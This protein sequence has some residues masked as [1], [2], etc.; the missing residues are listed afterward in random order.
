MNSN[1]DNFIGIF[2]NNDLNDYCS[3][4]VN[5]FDHIQGL[6]KTKSRQDIGTASKQNKDNEVYLF[7]DEQDPLILPEQ[8]G[9][10]RPFID[11]LDRCYKE[12]DNEC[13]G[14]L[15]ML[16]KHKLNPDIKIQKT[17]PGQGYHV[18]HCETNNA[19]YSRRLLLCMLYLNDV[20][21]GGETEFLYQSKR[22]S[23][24]A[25]RV[26]ICPAY[27]THTHRGNPPLKEAKYM[28][29]GWVEFVE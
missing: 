29:N 11:V 17:L 21:D 12:Y 5:F 8:F 20:K 7:M 26:V 15:Q 16:G 4:L 19:R 24:K 2:D 28:I 1:V 22:V 6:G 25:G 13:G 27:F 10:L 3:E 14:A 23:P 9:L 18:W